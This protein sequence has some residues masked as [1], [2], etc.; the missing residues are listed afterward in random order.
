[1]GKPSR[2]GDAKCEEGAEGTHKVAPPGRRPTGP[3]RGWAKGG[4]Q[5][6]SGGGKERLG[7]GREGV[8]GRG[9][10]AVSLDE[11]GNCLTPKTLT[12]DGLVFIPS[13]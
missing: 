10:A 4:L 3:E 6:G 8:R 2:K 1:M 7:E 13:W 12:P 5:L 11:G 9:Q